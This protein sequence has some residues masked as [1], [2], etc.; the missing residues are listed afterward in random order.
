MLGV[1]VG[2]TAE[3][4][5]TTLRAFSGMLHGETFDPGFVGP[6]RSGGLT[7]EKNSP[8]SRHCR[9]SATKSRRWT[10][11]ISMQKSRHERL[12]SIWKSLGGSAKERNVNSLASR[13]GARSPG[14]HRTL[15]RSSV[16]PRSISRAVRFARL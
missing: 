11:R 14:R 3:G 4:K 7:R 15:P 16:W 5:S 9:N 13:N 1:L 6:T 8:P 2:T 12:T 10:P